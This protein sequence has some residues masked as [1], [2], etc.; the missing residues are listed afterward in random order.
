MG[1]SVVKTDDAEKRSHPICSLAI[2]QNLGKVN[3]SPSS[4]RCLKAWDFQHQILVYYCLLH[5]TQLSV[6]L[7]CTT[8]ASANQLEPNFALKPSK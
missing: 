7:Q 6:G 4:P 2:V 1:A 5:Y 3:R 8:F